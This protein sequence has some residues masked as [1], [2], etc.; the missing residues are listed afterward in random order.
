M[1]ASTALPEP[2][3]QMGE[4]EAAGEPMRATTP[5]ALAF[6]E[7][8]GESM[9][10]MQQLVA[11][12]EQVVEQSNTDGL[13]YRDMEAKREQWGSL[14]VDTGPGLGREPA[15]ELEFSPLARADYGE[16]PRSVGFG[17]VTTTD[18][19]LD[20]EEAAETSPG[21]MAA[22]WDHA[23]ADHHSRELKYETGYD[24]K[25]MHGQTQHMGD[26]GPTMEADVRQSLLG[27]YPDEEEAS[28]LAGAIGRASAAGSLLAETQ[29]AFV[30]KDDIAAFDEAYP[31]PAV[32][33]P[34]VQQR[35][36]ARTIGPE[37]ELHLV[38]LEAR[39]L[40]KMCAPFL[41][42]PPS[43]CSSH[44]VSRMYTPAHRYD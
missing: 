36:V 1:A 24:A 29:K 43:Y 28:A 8:A 17:G 5:M 39:G 23:M 3:E 6:M 4:G 26:L 16:R 34:P 2:M 18:V 15:P 27:S 10:E 32:P 33:E 13:Q 41:R 35:R 44:T 12:V 14:L 42:P 30:S 11:G 20:G 37:G 9:R 7:A 21:G 19:P 40:P 38:V 25:V 31:A 22:G